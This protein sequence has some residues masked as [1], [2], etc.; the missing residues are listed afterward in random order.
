MSCTKIFALCRSPSLQASAEGELG[1]NWKYL[2]HPKFNN[3]NVGQR[4]WKLEMK[5]CI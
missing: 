2:N 3:S 5:L 4:V 1:E